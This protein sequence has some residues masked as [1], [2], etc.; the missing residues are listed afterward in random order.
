MS[1]LQWLP[2]RV[3]ILAMFWSLPIVI[4]LVI[5]LIALYQTGWLVIIAWS[6]PPVWLLAWIVGKL[7]SP[8]GL[9]E[10][11]SRLPLTAREF[12]TP[13]DTA[14]IKVVEE[15]R[16][17]V[18]DVDPIAI[19]DPIRYLSDARAIAEL[20]STHY[21][22]S[23]SKHAL[24][25]LTPIEIVAVIHLSVEDLEDWILQNVPGSTL[26]TMQQLE[27]IPALVKA[28]D[29]GQSIWF[30][31]S[32]I[33]NPGKLLSYPLWRQS[34][35]VTIELHKELIRTFYQVY[36]RQ[37]SY[38][39]IEMYSGRL[40]GGSR[41]FRQKFG[42]LAT[43]MH[44]SRGD[45]SLLAN[46]EAVNTTIAVI[47]QVKAGKSSLVNALMGDKVAATSILP[48]TRTVKRFEYHL[49]ESD[50]VL[51]L[52]DTPGYSEADVSRQQLREI[53]SAAE[54]ADIILLV[55]AANSPAR[56]ADLQTV[57]ALATHY[58]ERRHLKPPPIIAV[59]THID[60]LRPVREWSP[61]YNWRDPRSLKE[62]SIANAVAYMKEL[63]GENIAG[64]ACVYT[65][66]IDVDDN[67]VADE[68]VP[69]LLRSLDQGHSAAILKAFYQQLNRKKFQQL[70]SQVVGLLKSVGTQIGE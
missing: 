18:A 11:A 68:I 19:V 59:L 3:G 22:E 63:F 30:F 57:H 67:S 64:F 44:A 53:E 7:C 16:K 10:S 43:A 62:Q 54:A 17:H 60:L 4:Y 28:L 58:R 52:L 20:L 12:W 55:L 69:Q 51:N 6:L 47:G 48:E 13:H 38:Y 36:L 49:Q 40:K 61:P 27:Q 56:D 1:I 31:I 45:T 37:V 14:A 34:G 26:A 25:A 46:L 5:G 2:K 9:Q 23:N 50:K 42:H 32:T 24:H 65:G 35:R 21:H 33:A 15:F 66:Q 8:P 41:H 29:I 39:L 70:A